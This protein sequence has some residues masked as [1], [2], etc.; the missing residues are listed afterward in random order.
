[1]C[2]A[3]LTGQLMIPQRIKWKQVLF[4]NMSTLHGEPLVVYYLES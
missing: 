2:V 1:M 4:H 3:F